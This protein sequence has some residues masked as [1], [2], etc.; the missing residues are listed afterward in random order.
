[1]TVFAVDDGQVRVRS[2]SCRHEL[3][4][5]CGKVSSG[6]IVC[7]PNRLVATVA[8]VRSPYDAITG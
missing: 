5:N 3:C 2:S 1:V 7:A 6:R 4:R 8:G